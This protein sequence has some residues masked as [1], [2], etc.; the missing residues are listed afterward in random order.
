MP[1]PN[2]EQPRTICVDDTLR[3]RRF[4]HNY[5]IAFEW[6]QDPE[7]VYLVDGVKTPYTREILRNMYRYLDERGELYYI[8][9]RENGQLI[10]V[11]DVCFWKED[12]PIV[13][14]DPRYRRRGIGGKVIRALIERGKQL[15]YDKLYVN[16]I[17]NYNTASRACFEKAGFR[18]YEQ[19]GTGCRFVIDLK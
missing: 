4:D 1:I 11:G 15:G 9:V 7:T 8:E 10:P 3:L 16:E 14:G 5:E 13:I 17:Y 19:T 6:Y 2:I 12:M 18:A